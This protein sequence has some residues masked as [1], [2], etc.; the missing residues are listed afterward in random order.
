VGQGW[1]KDVDAG[2]A[3]GVVGDKEVQADDFPRG[4]NACHKDVGKNNKDKAPNSVN[5]R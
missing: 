1:V 2:T 4:R 3:K 5:N